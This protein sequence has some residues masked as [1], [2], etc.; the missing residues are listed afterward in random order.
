MS[1]PTLA[2]SLILVLGVV[3]GVY[4]WQINQP[5]DVIRKSD[6]RGGCKIEELINGDCIFDYIKMSR[7]EYYP[8]V[9]EDDGIWDR[10]DGNSKDE[11]LNV[12]RQEITK[13]ET[14]RYKFKEE[15]IAR[16][17]SF[18]D[19]LSKQWGNLKEVAIHP[20]TDIFMTRPFDRRK[21]HFIV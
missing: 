5:S 2:S 12:A 7:Y 19:I 18:I 14:W 4:I 15:Q 16:I 9:T 17:Q 6:Y 10:V 21:G 20:P 13:R 3:A 1:K 11:L 8:L